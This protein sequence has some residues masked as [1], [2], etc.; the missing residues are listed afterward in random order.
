[1]RVCLETVPKIRIKQNIKYISW[2]IYETTWIIYKTLASSNWRRLVQTT[3][4]FYCCTANLALLFS[5]CTIIVW[6]SHF[7]VLFNVDPVSTVIVPSVS[8][9]A[10]VSVLVLLGK[11][12]MLLRPALLDI[13]I[14]Y[15]D[16]TERISQWGIFLHF[17]LIRKHK[18]APR[19]KCEP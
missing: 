9:Q 11:K 16:I 6:L 3:D 13:S 14:Y 18:S 10:L 17:Q 12:L 2:I 15:D 5:S 7:V 1:M 4:R 8:L 19:Q